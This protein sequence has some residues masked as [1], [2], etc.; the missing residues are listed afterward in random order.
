MRESKTI[1]HS[2]GRISRLIE[3]LKSIY[4]SKAA[5]LNKMFRNEIDR[6]VWIK[7]ASQRISNVKRDIL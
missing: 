3:L 2:R 1:M 6:H 5:H 7:I 4:S